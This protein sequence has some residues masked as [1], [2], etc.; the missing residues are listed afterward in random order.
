MNMAQERASAFS[1][2]LVI[3]QIYPRS[4]MDSDGDGIGDLA[5]ILAKLDYFAGLGVNALWLC[6][7]YPSPQVDFGYD[8]ANYTD[9][10]PQYGTLADLDM[11]IDQAHKKGI[12][13]IM[14]LVLNHTSDQHPWFQE[15]R[16]SP[17]NPKRDWYIWKSPR[18][19]NRPPN[20]WLST[21]GGSAWELDAA[22]GRYYL[23]SFF[24]QQPDLNWENPA[25]RAALKEVMRFWLDRGV[26]GFRQ[27]AVYWYGKDQSFRDDPA[28]PDFDAR[29]ESPY[30]ELLHTHSKRQP[31]VFAHLNELARFLATYPDRFMIT[32]AYPHEP[33]NV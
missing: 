3:Y 17:D 32:E 28:N 7:V 24:K 25:V 31:S 5:G 20:N 8:V 13:I 27:D 1:P 26:D 14:D 15:S 19:G 4:F 18:A 29:E 10:D 12:K 16:S 33:F 2:G 23:H 21:F 9:V 11:L 6:P 30:D 22:T